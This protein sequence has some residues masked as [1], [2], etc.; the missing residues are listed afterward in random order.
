M[1]TPRRLLS[2]IRDQSGASAAEFAL[3]LAPLIMLTLGSINC[4]AM[5]YTSSA[6]H[7][8]VENTARWTAIKATAGGM[9]SS[10]DLQSHGQSVY[11]GATTSV[12][13]TA[14][15]A[16]CGIKITGVANYNF[17]TGLTS[18]IMPMNAVACYPMGTF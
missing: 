5:V 17:T 8:A 14:T 12:T 16:A 10:T 9:P 6:L 15:Q 7:Y 3:I 1:R 2:A 13:F 4:A 11:R 18:T